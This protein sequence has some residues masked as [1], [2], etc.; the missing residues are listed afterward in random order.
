MLIAVLEAKA[1]AKINH[2]FETTKYFGNFFQ[3]TFSKNLCAI[4]VIVLISDCG[5]K[6]SAFFL[7]SKLFVNFFSNF[8]NIF[9]YRGVIPIYIIYYRGVL[10]FWVEPQAEL[11]L[12]K[13][14]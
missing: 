1:G 5:C 12:G 11:A 4:S 14:G 3:K 6:G 7:S 8:F 13:T 10:L 9:K 2:I